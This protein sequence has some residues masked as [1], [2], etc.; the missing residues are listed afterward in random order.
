MPRQEDMSSKRTELVSVATAMINGEINLIEGIRKI[1][2]LRHHVESPDGEI[3]IPIRAIESETDHF[4]LGR[5]RMQCAPDYLKRADE[6]MERYVVDI[7]ADIVVACREIVRAY[8][9]APLRS[10]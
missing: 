3:F 6:E 9:R 10:I 7:K 5:A 8:S 2:A 4:P 1:T